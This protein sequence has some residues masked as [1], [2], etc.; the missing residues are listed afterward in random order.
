MERGF[1]ACTAGIPRISPTGDFV[2]RGFSGGLHTKPKE[3]VT[4]DLRSGLSF[5]LAPRD[6]VLVQ[7][8]TL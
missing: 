7:M 2:F 5:L 1:A 8:N 4:A 3:I 6:Q